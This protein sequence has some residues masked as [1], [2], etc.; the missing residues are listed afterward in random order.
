MEN[1][2]AEAAASE[3]GRNSAI[4]TQNV[5][6]R[7]KITRDKKAIQCNKDDAAKNKI[8]YKKI[9]AATKKRSIKK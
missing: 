8:K 5:I 1:T 2:T 4:T 9:Q 6:I 3:T 7:E